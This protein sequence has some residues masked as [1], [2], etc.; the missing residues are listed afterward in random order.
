MGE[1]HPICWEPEQNKNKEENWTCSLTVSWSISLLCSPL[2]VPMLSDSDLNLCCWAS[3]WQAFKPHHRPAWFSSSQMA[4]PGTAQPPS[5]F[6]KNHIFIYV[7]PPPIGFVFLENPNTTSL[8]TDKERR[9]HCADSCR[10]GVK[11]H[12]MAVSRHQK[13]HGTDSLPEPPEAAWP[14]HIFILGFW[15]LK[16]WE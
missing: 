12:R 14:C 13:N 11:G 1:H 15:P 9:R 3:A 2:L 16:L 10:D 7:Y 4:N 8:V 5:S 6:I